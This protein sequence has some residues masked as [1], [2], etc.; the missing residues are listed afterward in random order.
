[1][2]K[3]NKKIDLRPFQSKADCE[4]EDSLKAQYGKLGIPEVAERLKFGAGSHRVKVSVLFGKFNQVRTQGKG[5]LQQFHRAPG[6]AG[7]GGPAP[8][9]TGN[10]TRRPS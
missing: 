7:A 3:H 9:P 2:T 4:R 8:N 5:L 1:M 10:T 6:L